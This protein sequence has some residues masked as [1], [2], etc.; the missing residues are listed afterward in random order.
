MFSVV[1]SSRRIA[2]AR[3]REDLSRAEVAEHVRAGRQRLAAAAVDVAAGHRA[4][5][6]CVRVFRDWR[7]EATAR[8]Q[9]IETGASGALEDPPAKVV[10]KSNHVDLLTLSLADVA[11][12]QLPRA[13]VEREAKWV[14]QARRVDLIA[15]RS[16][17]C[18]RIVRRDGV[19]Q[20]AVD[21]DP[22]HLAQQVVDV[23][24]AVVGVVGRAAVAH[25]DVEKPVGAKRDHAAVV[26]GK[27]LC[28]DQKH[29]LGSRAPRFGLAER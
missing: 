6:A 3:P 29:R 19:W 7:R 11:H 17:P 4:S 20:G 9:R 1:S 23:L 13:T 14:A 16:P 15:S 2:A 27:R 25:A 26:V 12:V 8:A 10:A 18:K 24:G 28:D 22:E 5:T 21:V